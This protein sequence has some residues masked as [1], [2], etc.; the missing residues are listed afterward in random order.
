[1]N[2]KV[3]L[4][5]RHAWYRMMSSHPFSTMMM[6]A[7]ILCPFLCCSIYGYST[8]NMDE[9]VP[10][11]KALG[12][13]DVDLDPRWFGY[14]TLPM[15]LFSTMYAVIYGAYRI[16]GLVDSKLEFASLLF[17]NEAIFFISARLLCCFAYLL[18]SAL[19]AKMFYISYR[20]KV[21]CI[22][23]FS[24]LLF[25]PDAHVAMNSIR[26]DTFVFLFL[27]LSIYFSCFYQ[28]N[29]S[30]FI[31]SIIFCG[32]AIA[33]KIPAI[34]FAPILFVSVMWDV[35][36]QAYPKKFL[37]LFPAILL[38]SVFCFMPY[39]FIS[40][41]LFLQSWSDVVNIGAE[42][43]VHFGKEFYSGLVEKFLGIFALFKTNLGYFGLLAACVYG[44][45]SAVR[46]K[47]TILPILYVGGYSSLFLRSNFIEEY[48]LRPVYPF[49]LLFAFSLFYEVDF[50]ILASRFG[51]KLFK[52]DFNFSKYIFV[53]KL[54]LPLLFI[55]VF[56]MHNA[57]VFHAFYNDFTERREETRVTSAKWIKSHLPSGSIIYMHGLIVHYLPRLFSADP[58][59]TLFGYCIN[60]Y[61]ETITKNKFLTEA[62]LCYFERQIHSGNQPN[63]SIEFISQLH[64]E[65][66]H[67]LERNTYVVMSSYTFDRYLNNDIEH[68]PESVKPGLLST[69]IAI[70]FLRNQKPI[71]SF[72]GRGPRIEIYQIE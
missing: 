72:E 5:N 49:L 45:I 34:V 15:Y 59:V 17:T 65:D 69:K 58:E 63:Y 70:E 7:L 52:I 11:V 64:N 28:K 25:L 20:S 68:L 39:A 22:L 4:F 18:G 8:W 6:L 13:L 46:R 16:F 40:Y 60:G 2:L 51:N 56:F 31:L 9:E 47:K 23:L 37:L 71:A 1:M 55:G 29:L 14:H 26:V 50:P 35:N 27:T 54:L 66:I 19:I 3:Q 21:G 30:S 67:F 42:P 38:L 33:S 61:G 12:F 32:A 24:M 44:A 62:F 43:N 36:N 57:T 48:W 53:G 41:K 10:V